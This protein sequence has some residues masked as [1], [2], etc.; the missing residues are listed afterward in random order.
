MRLVQSRTVRGRG[1]VTRDRGKI[2]YRAVLEARV[3]VLEY[4]LD[5]SV[6]EVMQRVL[7]EAESLTGSCI[8]FFHFVDPDQSTLKL[9]AWSS[10][11]KSEYCRAEGEDS[12]YPVDAAGV[13]VD[14]LRTKKP[15]IYNDYQALPHKKGL[16]MGHADVCRFIQVPIYR[17]EQ[18]VAIIGVGNKQSDYNQ[19]DVDVIAELADLT[20]DIT[21]R[22]I[23]EEA[24]RRS[25]AIYDAILDSVK[26]PI[27]ALDR[28]GGILAANKAY[29]ETLSV[30]GTETSLFGKGLFS[31]AGTPDAQ[32]T[33]GAAI[34][35]GIKAVANGI[36]PR[37]EKEYYCAPGKHEQWCRVTVYPLA[38]EEGGVVIIHED[39]TER[40]LTESKLSNAIDRYRSLFELFPAGIVI[41]NREGKILESNTIAR[42]LLG[43][44]E[45]EMRRRTIDGSEWY[46]CRP[47]G[48]IMPPEE[49][50]L[51]RAM[52]EGR[53]VTGVEMGV[54]NPDGDIRWISVSAAPVS[55]RR[56]C[57]CRGL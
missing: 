46:V 17:G 56:I 29:K 14:C 44:G 4:A 25:E 13:W 53:L 57:R 12:H 9:Q 11:T 18:A 51:V 41:S 32:G 20:W 7:D 55:R 6:K 43:I 35:E 2:D 48:S 27:V 10:R 47:D 26:V 19:N 16:P 34:H 39:I 24:V 3:R 42:E 1:P 33:D 22:K 40:H 36:L 45:E 49:F 30:T 52:R 54:R 28:S 38:H 23:A 50:A 31:C 8:G 15:I 21:S 5:H 37:F